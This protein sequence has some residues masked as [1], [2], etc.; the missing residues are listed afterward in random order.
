[1]SLEQLL[2]AQVERLGAKLERLERLAEQEQTRQEALARWV[3][4]AGLALPLAMHIG[5]T[6]LEG[7]L[8]RP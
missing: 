4:V 8:W 3:L 7:W 5:L 6:L 2:L 1:M